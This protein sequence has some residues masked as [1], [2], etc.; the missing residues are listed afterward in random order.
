MHQEGQEDN[1]IKQIMY[2]KCQTYLQMKRLAVHTK[3]LNFTVLNHSQS[4]RLKVCVRDR[5][6]S[7]KLILPT[8]K[9]QS[10]VSKN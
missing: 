9:L 3:Q 7:I 2:V 6:R 4:N 5:E 10:S 8:S 1:Y